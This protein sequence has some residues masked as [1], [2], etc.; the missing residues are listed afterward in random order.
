MWRAF[1]SWNG[2]HNRPAF[3]SLNTF[4]CKSKLTTNWTY[5]IITSTKSLLIKLTYLHNIYTLITKPHKIFTNNI[6][7]QF[8]SYTILRKENGG[9]QR[10]RDRIFY[11]RGHKTTRKS[12]LKPKDIRAGCG[13][14]LLISLILARKFKGDWRGI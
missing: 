14:L 9:R 6:Y 7:L 3:S 10:Q 8:N 11:K 12:N 1:L 5:Y 2:S 4:I 13:V